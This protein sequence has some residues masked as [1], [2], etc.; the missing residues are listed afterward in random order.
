MNYLELRKKYP[1]FEYVNYEINFLKGDLVLNFNY[2][3]PPDHSFTH[4]IKINGLKKKPEDRVLENIVFNIGL[5][6][7][8]SYWKL[9]ASPKIKIKAGS[10]DDFQRTW[11]AKLLLKGM[12]QY[13]YENEIN[14]RADD[15]TEILSEGPNKDFSLLMMDGEKL[16][17]PVGG[18]KDSAVTL[19]LL[20]KAK[21]PLGTFVVNANAASLETIKKA[22]VTDIVKVERM[23]DP[24]V[25]TL[26]REGYLNGHIPFSASLAFIGVLSAYLFG[27]K[28]L[29]FSN[30]RS[31][32]EENTKYLGEE[33]N[34][35]YSKTFE[36]E[37]DFREYNQRYLSDIQYFSFLRPL[38]EIQ[39]A[40]IFSQY[41]KYFETIRSCNVGAKENIWCEACP[42]CLST[43]ILLF[44]YLGEE[45][46]K[47]IFRKNLLE[48]KSLK[49][50]LSELTDESKVKP[51]ECVGTRKELKAALKKD[52]KEFEGSWGEN[53]IPEKLVNVLKEAV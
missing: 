33:I 52:D 10:I 3:I 7:M 46:I 29:A 17:I 32:D 4:T 53:N 8:F 49:N 44:P 27:F 51:F 11:L 47:G 28:E 50:L 22:K 15:F 14:F 48:D 36:F 42:K 12:G 26:N 40:K 2:K 31:S 1:E 16:L 25:L 30:E 6:E 23:I 9:T 35:Q 13:F 43:Y 37:N 38:Y 21:Y 24:A 18:G 20:S 41:D 39:I 45:K 34:H 19:E 5:V